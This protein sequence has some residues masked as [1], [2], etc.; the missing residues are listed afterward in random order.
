L[1]FLAVV[2]IL[3]YG[4]GAEFRV[5]RAWQFDERRSLGVPGTDPCS[6]VRGPREPIKETANRLALVTGG[7]GFIG[8]TLCEL[9]L[10]LG[11][12]VRVLDNLSTGDRSFVPVSDALEFVDGDVREYD[13][14]VKAMEGARFVFH[15]AAMSKVEPSLS[16]PEMMRY[17]L[18]VNA[19]GT[20]N[21]MRAALVETRKAKD[22]KIK[23]VY[24]ASS[25]HYGNQRTPF[26]ESFPEILSSPYAHSKRSGE[27]VVLLYDKLHDVPSISLRLFMV[28]GKREPSDGAYRVVTGTFL[29]QFSNDQALTIEG[30]GSHFRDFVHVADVARAFVMAA[31]SEKARGVSVNV[32]SGKAVTIKQVADLIDPHHQRRVAAREHDLVGTL[33]DTCAAKRVLGFEAKRD[34]ATEMQRAVEEMEVGKN[35]KVADG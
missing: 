18:D 34:F 3:A 23:V 9:L 13:V 20:E 33:A 30:D 28:Y 1:V 16:D 4:F 15:L 5:P 27:S 11:F 7:A 29:K 10:S 14:V 19:L 22:S 24:A 35:V 26:H 32:G 8:S 6:G 31:Q 25:T 21:V 17:C 2:A 12:R